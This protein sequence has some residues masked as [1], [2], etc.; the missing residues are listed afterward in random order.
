MKYSEL[1]EMT[2]KEWD[3]TP[4]KA[5]VTDN[6]D[7]IIDPDYIKTIISFI[8]N[9]EFPWGTYDDD[10]FSYVYPVEWNESTINTPKRMTNLQLAQWL[11]KGNGQLSYSSVTALVR[12]VH[13]VHSYDLA[14][15]LD[16][17]SDKILVREW[18]SS[19][20]IEPTV[21]LLDKS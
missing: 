21:D 11:A 8:A 6:P 20:W 4:F 17:C 7:N 12:G 9:N 1:K 13:I 15:E 14:N 5:Y 19:E 18:G 10:R 3:G 2:I 16:E